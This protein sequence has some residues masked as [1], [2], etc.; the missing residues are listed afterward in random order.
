[1]KKAI[2]QI[3]WK[4]L[5]FMSEFFPRF[6]TFLSCNSLMWEPIYDQRIL[7][8]DAK[9]NTKS[10]LYMYFLLFFYSLDVWWPSYP[11]PGWSSVYIQRP[12]RVYDAPR[13]EREQDVP[14]TGSDRSGTDR[15]R[16]HDQ[17]HRVYCVRCQGS[18]QCYTASRTQWRQIV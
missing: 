6:R 10:K 13:A 3:S 11:I 4:C 1:M 9:G 2:Y 8:C 5:Y 17:R 18:Q 7:D 15:W 14:A 12:G 16:Q